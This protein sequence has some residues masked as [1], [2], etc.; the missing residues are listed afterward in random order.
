MDQRIKIPK[1]LKEDTDSYGEENG[2]DDDMDEEG[3]DEMEEED[4]GDDMENEVFA[5]ARENDEMGVKQL[6]ELE[7]PKKKT[8]ANQEMIEKI[9]KLE[10]EMMDEKKWQLKG[11][12]ACKDRNYNSLLEE[13]VDFDTATKLPPQ[14]TKETTNAI[15]SL[16]KQRIL[17][18]LFDDP[19]R[20]AVVEGKKFND[21]TLNFTKSGKGLG[22]EYAEDYSKKLAEINKDVFLDTDPDAPIKREIDDIFNGLMRNLN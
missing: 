20:K 14:I 10:D 12:V 8:F 18:E 21:F 13:F 4:E 1:E 3:E 17:D 11:E 22:D 9:E 16:I 2:F 19:L 5:M 6:A 7:Q 15:E